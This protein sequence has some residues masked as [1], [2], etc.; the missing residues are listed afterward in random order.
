MTDKVDEIALRVLKAVNDC[1]NGRITNEELRSKMFQAYGEL[2]ESQ[3]RI[4][5]ELRSHAGETGS[6]LADAAADVLEA[7]FRK[8][9]GNA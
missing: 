1:K 2:E 9:A 8:G 5:A 7:E 3:L 4:I 6:P